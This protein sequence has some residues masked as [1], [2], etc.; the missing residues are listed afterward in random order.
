VIAGT[1]AITGAASLTTTTKI[2]VKSGTTGAAYVPAETPAQ[3]VEFPEAADAFAA[4][5]KGDV[6][7]VVIDIPIIADYIKTHPGTIMLAGGP[8]TEE[9]YAIAVS[10]DRPEIVSLLD[11]AVAKLRADGTYQILFQKWFGMP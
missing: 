8:L 9:A 1:H 2:G 11:D 4:L 10:K 6:D 3:A 7:A 5:E